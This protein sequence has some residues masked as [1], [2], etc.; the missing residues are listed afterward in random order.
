MLKEVDFKNVEDLRDSKTNIK[1]NKKY[2]TNRKTG[3]PI[4]VGGKLYNKLM[5]D[6][7]MEQTD[8]PIKTIEKFET[9]REAL[10]HKEFLN[11]KNTND[12][13]Y[14]ALD[15]TNKKVIMRKKRGKLICVN[16]VVDNMTNK[17]VELIDE[18]DISSFSK[19]KLKTMIL[20]RLISKK[21]Y[22]VESDTEEE[23]EE[24]EEEEVN[25]YETF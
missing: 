9:K 23:E 2:I 15:K 1:K 7:D 16:N 24:E 20:Q 6:T 21:R 13:Y 19:T 3:R 8:K 12:N 17:V 5:L 11:N 14:Y 10:H 25:V 4:L 18:Y 22:E